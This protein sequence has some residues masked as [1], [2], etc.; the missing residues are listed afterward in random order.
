MVPFIKP[1]MRVI[2]MLKMITPRMMAMVI[3]IHRFRRDPV[4]ECFSTF[5]E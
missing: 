2:T 1:G 3:L 5:E 4:A